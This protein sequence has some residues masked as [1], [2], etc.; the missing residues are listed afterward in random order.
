VGGPA[1]DPQPIGLGIR[2]GDAGMKAAVAAA[3]AAIYADGTMKSIVDK[4]G[5]ADAVELLK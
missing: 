4:W 1:I 5:I 2:K 3:V